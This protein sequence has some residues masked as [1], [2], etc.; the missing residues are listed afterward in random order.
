VDQP[1][2]HRAARNPKRPR[3]VRSQAVQPAGVLPGSRNKLVAY[4]L[5][6]I[7]FCNENDTLSLIYIGPVALLLTT[8]HATVDVSDKIK[9]QG[10]SSC[11]FEDLGLKSTVFLKNKIVAWPC[12]GAV[13]R[14]ICVVSTVT[15]VAYAASSTV[16][17][18]YLSD[19]PRLNRRI[20][21]A[22]PTV[23][24]NVQVNTLVGVVF[25]FCKIVRHFHSN[26]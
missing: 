21:R 12:N 7:F 18:R 25:K 16:E 24:V 2:A 3:A 1:W 23:P 19:F 6:E 11:I 17:A 5:H 10:L 22:N 9:I 20:Q 8:A 4:S 13:F 15:S 14:A 26:I